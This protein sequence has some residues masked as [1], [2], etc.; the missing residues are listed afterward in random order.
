MNDMYKQLFGEMAN[1]LSDEM[2]NAGS[3]MV[4]D[5]FVNKIKEAIPDLSDQALSALTQAAVEAAFLDLVTVPKVTASSGIL[6]ELKPTG[7]TD[8]EFGEDMD[9]SFDEDD[10]DPGESMDLEEFLDVVMGA[11]NNGR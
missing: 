6:I 5:V 7:E 4:A 1:N 9:D 3:A 11:L 10:S 2:I 8:N